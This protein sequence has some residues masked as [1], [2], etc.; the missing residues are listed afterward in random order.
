[1]DIT[2]LGFQV[3]KALYFYFSTPKEHVNKS[4]VF[5]CGA[6]AKGIV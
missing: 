4:I 2:K 3:D 5:L 6:E 1:M